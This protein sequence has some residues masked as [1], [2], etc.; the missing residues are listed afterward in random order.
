MR[1]KP[2]PQGGLRHLAL[3][4]RNLRMTERFYIKILGLE[5]AFRNRG[6]IF[7]RSPGGD[8]LLNFVE[9]NRPFDPEQG[10]LDHFGLRFG[11]GEL[12]KLSQ[13]L[14][15]AEIPALGRRGRRSLYVQD[16]NGYTIELYSD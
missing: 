13:T 9:T 7:F 6:M 4:T 11:R 5:V 15:K 8:D 10:G 2:E 12:K 14:R 16:P 1:V 3:K